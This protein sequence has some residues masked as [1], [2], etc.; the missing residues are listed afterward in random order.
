MFFWIYYPVCLYQDKNAHQ[1]W[2]KVFVS[3]DNGTS[4]QQYFGI[5]K[6]MTLSNYYKIQDSLV[7]VSNDQVFTLNWS[8]SDFYTRTP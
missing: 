5:T 3:S 6:G 1:E 7:G 2:N 4:W 8:G